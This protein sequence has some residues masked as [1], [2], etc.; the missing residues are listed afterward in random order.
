ML[1]FMTV[2]MS[3]DN[4]SVKQSNFIALYLVCFVVLRV[5]YNG[6]TLFLPKLLAL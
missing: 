4:L 1:K 2:N 3:K 5:G 6:M